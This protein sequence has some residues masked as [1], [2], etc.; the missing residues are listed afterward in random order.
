M[1]EFVAKGNRLV[2]GGIGS[3]YILP[4]QIERQRHDVLRE[5][6]EIAC[7]MDE[8]V[9][10]VEI[11]FVLFLL[12]QL[13]LQRSPFHVL[14]ACLDQSDCLCRNHVMCVKML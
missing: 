5:L 14:T 12:F 6:G 2:L 9:L 7:E 3:R 13:F 11:R 8:H 1:K 4:R 10:G